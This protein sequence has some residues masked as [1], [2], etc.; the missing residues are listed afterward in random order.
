[1]EPTQEC[2]LYKGCGLS[3]RPRTRARECTPANARPRTRARTFTL[4]LLALVACKFTVVGGRRFTGPMLFELH[5]LNFK[6]CSKQYNKKFVL[7][8]IMV[9]QLS[10]GWQHN[11]STK[12][13]QAG[14]ANEQSMYSLTSM[15]VSRDM[16]FCEL[17]ALAHT[18]PYTAVFK[19]L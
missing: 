3:A 8:L 2:K 7:H 13:R 1:M 17:W 9:Q 6:L 15:I 4:R 5:S 18:G 12:T 19:M 16:C 11:Y 14:Q 10:S